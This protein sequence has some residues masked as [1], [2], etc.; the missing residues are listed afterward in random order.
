M[1]A[2]M[3]IFQSPKVA[4]MIANVKFKPAWNEKVEV[5]TGHTHVKFTR[6]RTILKSRV[7]YRISKHFLLLVSLGKYLVT[8]I[9]TVHA[10]T[11]TH[12]L[13][14]ATTIYFIQLATLS[15][16]H[17]AKWSQR[18]GN[19][20]PAVLCRTENDPFCS[21]AWTDFFPTH[22]NM[23]EGNNMVFSCAHNETHA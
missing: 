13:Y 23:H 2:R 3:V 11:L 6:P 14:Q 7:S 1:H 5:E 16:Q 22:M 17:N 4:E 19:I 21:W 18:A 10:L 20:I 15:Q 9:Y 12:Y 8:I